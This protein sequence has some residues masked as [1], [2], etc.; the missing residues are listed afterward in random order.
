MVKKTSLV[1]NNNVLKSMINDEPVLSSRGVNAA[2]R[3]YGQ[4]LPEILIPGELKNVIPFQIFGRGVF[5]FEC[6]DLD[7]KILRD[8]MKKCTRMSAEISLVSEHS[9]ALKLLFYESGKKEWYASFQVNFSIHKGIYSGGGAN[10]NFTGKK[11][12]FK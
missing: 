4:L 6:D 2:C 7:G 9:V 11:T 12:S 1:F 3:F 10:I 8:A 5:L